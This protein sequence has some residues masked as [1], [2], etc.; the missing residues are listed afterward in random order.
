[1]Y[2]SILHATDLS[3]NHF[4][5]CQQAVE[6]AKRFKA[7]LYLLHVI[8]QPASMIIAQG[9]GFTEIESP[10]PMLQDAQMVMSVLGDGLKIPQN[11]LFVELGSVVHR[12]VHKAADLECQLIII[13]HHMPQY[14]SNTARTIVDEAKCDVLTLR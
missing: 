10:E 12:I 8:E 11:K 9:L 13:G 7:D 1:M 2:T 14:M 4:E 6:I 5:M 3:E